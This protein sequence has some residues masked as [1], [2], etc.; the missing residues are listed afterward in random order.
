[1]RLGTRLPGVPRPGRLMVG[2]EEQVP[3]SVGAGRKIQVHPV[4]RSISS[5]QASSV[6]PSA[7]TYRATP[8]MPAITNP[9]TKKA[10]AAAAAARASEKATACLAFMSVH[11]QGFGEGGRKVLDDHRRVK[12]HGDH[13]G[14]DQ[15][16][17][18]PDDLPGEQ[19]E[20]GGEP[21]DPQEQGT[22]Q[23]LQVI[24]QPLAG[25]RGGHGSSRTRTKGRS[26]PDMISGPSTYTTAGPGTGSSATSAGAGAGDRRERNR[27]A[28]ADRYET[29]SSRPRVPRHSATSAATG[30]PRF[31]PP[32]ARAAAAGVAARWSSRPRCRTA[33]RAP[34]RTPGTAAPPGT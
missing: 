7:V 24:H 4:L 21:D 32:P 34:A 2:A 9:I 10:K 19:E 3:V 5:P 30:R 17:R 33:P 15:E 28:H 29:P 1:D 13:H 22:E 23:A 18:E 31:T 16:L 8:G 11:S 26:G 25:Q 6:A 20:H 27:C 14:Q 12:D